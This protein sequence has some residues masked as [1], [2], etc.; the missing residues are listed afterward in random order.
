MFLQLG[1]SALLAAEP[2]GLDAE[3]LTRVLKPGALA[4][5]Q[6]VAADPL[7]V[8]H[9]ALGQGA[10]GAM[11]VGMPAVERMAQR[12]RPTGHSLHLRGGRAIAPLQLVD[13]EPQSPLQRHL[14]LT[15]PL[16]ELDHLRGHPLALVQMIRTPQ[17][18]MQCHQAPDHGGRVA[19]ILGQ[20][21]RD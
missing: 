16:G 7:G 13:E 18:E 11:H 10:H 3:G 5:E 8:V 17:R 12:A 20:G 19:G 2:K 14:G 15:G 9:A 21:R 1:E 4:E 6:G